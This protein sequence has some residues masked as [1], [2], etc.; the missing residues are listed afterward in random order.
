[1]LIR[2]GANTNVH[3]KARLNLINEP[4]IIGESCINE[5]CLIQAADT[6][7]MVVGNGVLV[8]CNTN[9]KKAN[10]FATDCTLCP[11]TGVMAQE[12]LPDY[13]VI[14]GYNERTVAIKH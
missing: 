10:I 5:R 4:I 3:P 12:I 13:T 1:Y 11:M 14:Y 8:E 6:G 9:V 7:G 2:I